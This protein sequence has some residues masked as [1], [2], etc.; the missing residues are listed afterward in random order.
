M[1]EICQGYI[2]PETV[3]LRVRKK[4]QYFRTE[5]YITFKQKVGDRTIELESD[6]DS[7]DGED[8]WR[9]CV[10]KLTKTRHTFHMDGLLSGLELD[11]FLAENDRLPYFAMAEVEMP[12]GASPPNL[13]EW[14]RWHVLFEV[15]LT[16]D[17]FSN[18]MLGDQQYACELYKTLRDI[19][20][21]RS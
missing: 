10:R 21:Q 4:T 1:A 17:R 16:D 14:L 15:P 7:R 8:L 19:K 18:K 20:L 11:V 12:E 2:S 6:I 9:I 3:N 13:P 5:W